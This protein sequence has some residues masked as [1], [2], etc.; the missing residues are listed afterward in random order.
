MMPKA[1]L[2]TWS[3]WNHQLLEGH[4]GLELVSV[5]ELVLTSSQRICEQPGLT[6]LYPDNRVY[7]SLN[8]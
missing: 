5:G 1:S 8:I 3:V 4:G 6:I 7:L 2:F